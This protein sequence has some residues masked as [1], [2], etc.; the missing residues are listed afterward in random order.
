MVRKKTNANHTAGQSRQT[1]PVVLNKSPPLADTREVTSLRLKSARA[2]AIV[3]LLCGASCPVRAQ[4]PDTSASE[5]RRQFE[6]WQAGQVEK[7]RRAE[8]RYQALESRYQS[9]LHIVETQPLDAPMPADEETPFPR[10]EGDQEARERE[11]HGDDFRVPLIASFHDGVE[12]ASPDE[13]YSLRIHLLNQVDFKV[14]VPGDQEPARSGIYIPRFRVYFEGRVTRP[15]EYEMSIQRSVE[16][17]FDVLDADVNFHYWDQFQLKF[18]RFLVPYS[19]DWYNHLEQYFITPE[20]GLFPLNFGLSREAGLMAWGWLFD[21]RLEYA[22]G[23]FDGQLFGLADTNTTRDWV[24]YVNAIPFRRTERFPLL[25]FLNFGGSF[26]LGQ[27]TYRAAPLPLRTSVQSSENDEAAQAAS[28]DFLEW[29]DD[30]VAT[31]SRIQGAIHFAWY[32][33]HLS[34]EAEWQIGR[35]EY[36]RLGVY[37]LVNVPVTGF[38]VAAGYFITGETVQKRTTVVPLRPF[39]PLKGQRGPGAIE[40]FARYTQLN[41][42]DNVF[43]GGLA[44]PALW[45]NSAYVTDTGFNWY[46]NRF[47]KFYVDWQ[48]SSFGRRILL[49]E[50]KQKFGF[51]SDLLWLRMQL[52]Y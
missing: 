36:Q 28:V 41:L 9:L 1:L 8:D 39:N 38:H 11:D 35:F 19:Y 20:R 13:D 7:E 42:G 17:T 4:E 50:G 51:N 22:T 14:F 45:S 37:P 25:R 30:V 33:N 46:P 31:G 2:A 47:I 10:I 34:L 6:A 15:I 48:H 49:N 16:G 26:A 32:V 23:G 29:N 24:T 18:G 44:D 27:Q 40:L 21:H 52:Y 12:L 5:L 43:T 3:L